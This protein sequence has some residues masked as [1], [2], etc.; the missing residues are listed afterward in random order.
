M[1]LRGRPGELC[2]HLRVLPRDHGQGPHPAVVREWPSSLEQGTRCHPCAWGDT[3]DLL[4]RPQVEA[5]QGSGGPGAGQGRAE[6]KTREESIGALGSQ[7]RDCGGDVMRKVLERG[8][9]CWKPKCTESNLDTCGT[10]AGR[11]QPGGT[12]DPAEQVGAPALEMEGEEGCP[13]P[14]AGG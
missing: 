6:G 11:G 5:G 8:E 4:E 12:P 3:G 10:A 9:T 14:V 1:L 2:L 13:F 7:V